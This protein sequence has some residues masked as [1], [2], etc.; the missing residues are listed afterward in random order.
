MRACFF[1]PTPQTHWITPCE[2]PWQFVPENGVKSCVHFCLQPL[3]PL[4]TCD[5]FSSAVNNQLIFFRLCKRRPWVTQSKSGSDG[6]RRRWR[7]WWGRPRVPGGCHGVPPDGGPGGPGQANAEACL[8]WIRPSSTTLR[9]ET[10]TFLLTQNTVAS[11]SNES[12]SFEWDWPIL[13]IT[14]WAL[15]EILKQAFF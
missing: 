10:L 8:R 6:G 2:K 3:M 7:G 15:F 14:L 9:Y 12:V 1:D 4:E 5:V 13:N 11:Y